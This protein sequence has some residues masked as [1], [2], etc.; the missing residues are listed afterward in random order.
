MSSVGKTQ[1]RRDVF[2]GEG[3][4]EEYFS[5]ALHHWE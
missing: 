3:P 1:E 5:F 2:P 4:I